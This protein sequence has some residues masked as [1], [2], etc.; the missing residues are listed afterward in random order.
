[1]DLIYNVLF[2]LLTQHKQH[3]PFSVYFNQTWGCGKAGVYPSGHR[4]GGTPCDPKAAVVQHRTSVDSRPWLSRP[5]YHT[6]S[7]LQST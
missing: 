2:Y 6:F 4:G 3:S 7:K 5:F 1:M